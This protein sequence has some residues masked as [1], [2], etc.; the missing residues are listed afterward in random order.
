MFV[1]D[2]HRFGDVADFQ[3]LKKRAAAMRAETYDWLFYRN[4]VE[5]SNGP[6][7]WIVCKDDWIKYKPSTFMDPRDIDNADEGR[8]TIG[9][10]KNGPSTFG[11]S[12]QTLTITLSS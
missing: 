1:A 12:A 11:V 10:R 7:Y 8:F 5:K 3:E 2:V 4:R 9:S 6:S